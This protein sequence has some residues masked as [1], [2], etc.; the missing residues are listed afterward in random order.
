VRIIEA[1][2]T[3]TGADGSRADDERRLITTLLHPAVMA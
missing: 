1:A 2:V 3:M